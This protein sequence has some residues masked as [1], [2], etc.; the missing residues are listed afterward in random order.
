MRKLS[1]VSTWGPKEV[2][3]RR[4]VEGSREGE[5]VWMN[6]WM[7]R[8]GNGGGRCGESEGEV[9]SWVRELG[10]GVKIKGP[11]FLEG[12]GGGSWLDGDEWRRRGAE[13]TE[14]MGQSDFHGS[15]KSMPARGTSCRKK[16]VAV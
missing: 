7:G 1:A 6:F 4:A 8:L 15:V 13:C 10:D 2:A 9:W 14:E 16:E 12:C 11:R 5:E 3:I